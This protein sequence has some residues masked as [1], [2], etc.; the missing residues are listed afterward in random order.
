MP[1][2]DRGVLNEIDVEDGPADTDVI[3]VGQNN[4]AIDLNEP[5]DDVIIAAD[6]PLYMKM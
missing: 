4:D 2:K 5:D 6:K 1:E 3:E